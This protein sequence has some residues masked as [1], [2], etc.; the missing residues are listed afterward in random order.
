M[1]NCCIGNN[2]T[3]LL[4]TGLFPAMS[5][6]HRDDQ[7]STSC[8]KAVQELSRLAEEYHSGCFPIKSLKI[9]DL[10]YIEKSYKKRKLEDT[11]DS[12]ECTRCPRFKEHV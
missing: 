3:F 6:L 8:I 1:V 9:G 2:V 4:L 10:E 7:P 11:L 5:S 12:Y